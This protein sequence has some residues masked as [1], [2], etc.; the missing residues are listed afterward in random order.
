MPCGVHERICDAPRNE[1]L[2]GKF[3]SSSRIGVHLEVLLEVIF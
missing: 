2:E 1:G 3:R